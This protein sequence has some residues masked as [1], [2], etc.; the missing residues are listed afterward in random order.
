MTAAFLPT[1]V[2]GSEM[3]FSLNAPYWSLFFEIV[4]NIIYVLV[5]KKLTNTINILIILVSGAGLVYISHVSGNLDIGYSWSLI[6][7]AAGAARSVF[8][9]FVGY[10]IYKNLG[11]FENILKFKYSRWISLFVMLTIFAV[12]SSEAFNKIFDPLVV[13]VL[14][15]ILMVA[16]TKHDA[17]DSGFKILDLVGFVSYPLYVLHIP[18]T[19]L[20]RLFMPDE[21]TT[22]APF[23][24]LILMAAMLVI[25][26][27]LTKY[28]DIPVRR[29]LNHKFV[30][31]RK[32]A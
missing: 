27:L 24:G 31:A 4:V 26:Y 28:Y 16:F 2:N 11:L 10:Y 7:L 8:G 18:L 30:R 17:T 20:P 29:Y 15:P 6:S 3:L 14:F 13:I 25:S 9:F 5:A 12:P 23:S 32:L 1:H 21:M 19:R 22:Y